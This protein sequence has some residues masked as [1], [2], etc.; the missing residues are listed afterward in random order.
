MKLELAM[1]SLSPKCNGLAQLV[2]DLHAATG[3]DAAVEQGLLRYQSEAEVRVKSWLRTR[4]SL[5]K[6]IGRLKGLA[7]DVWLKIRHM[8][9]GIETLST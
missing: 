1:S 4:H 6:A 2:V 9:R 8:E 5:G 7:G 3:E